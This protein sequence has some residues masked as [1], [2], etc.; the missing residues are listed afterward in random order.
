MSEPVLFFFR[1]KQDNCNMQNS[2][3][4]KTFLL[5]TAEPT[6]FYE[7]LLDNLDDGVYFIDK[8]RTIKYWNHAAEKLSGYSAK[9]VIG[10]S[11]ADNILVHVDGNGNQL[12]LNGCPLHACMTDG[13]P[14]EAS[15]FMHHKKGHRVSVQVKANPILD[16]NNRIIGAVEIFRDNSKDLMV[17]ERIKHLE[18][19]SLIDD[20]TGVGNRRFAE[21]TLSTKFYEL[22]RYGWP[23]GLIFADIDDFKAVNDKFGHNAGDEVLKSVACC[24]KESVRGLDAVFRWG[25]DEFI[26]VISNLGVDNAIHVS[27]RMRNIVEASLITAGSETIKIKLSIGVAVAERSDSIDSII[28][29]AD[30]A[31]YLSKN[32]RDVTCERNHAKP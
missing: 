27:E 22:N 3:S 26:A 28:K 19:L 4:R 31:M 1:R 8:N 30:K 10:L 11:C 7:S 20:L 14:R 2:I 23:F 16:K 25:G 29:R 18:K 17:Q 12:C 6:E 24:M 21:I 5:E 9:E 13:Q 32:S 15:V